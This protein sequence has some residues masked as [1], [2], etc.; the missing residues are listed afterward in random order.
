MEI[1]IRKKKNKFEKFLQNIKKNKNNI[2]S[3][4]NLSLD[5]KLIVIRNNQIQIMYILL[6]LIIL[7]AIEVYLQ[8]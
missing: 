1:V 4:D 3:W 7:F 8:I 2:D 6:V 5:K